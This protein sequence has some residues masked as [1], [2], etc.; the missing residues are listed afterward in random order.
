MTARHTDLGLALLD[1]EFLQDPYPLYARMQAEGAV[2]RV[3]ASDFFAVCGRAAVEEAVA[4]PDTFSSNLTGAIR[5]MPDGTVDLLPLDSLGSPTQALATADDPAHAAHRRMLIPHLAAKRIGALE[6]FVAQTMTALWQD[7]TDVGVTEWMSAVANPLPMKVICEL[8]GIPREDTDRVGQWAYASTQVL[9]GRVDDPKLA[10][11][12]TAALELAG[13]I[14]EQMEASAA[15][16]GHTLL[17][18]LARACGTGEV[19]LITAQVMLVTLFS[20]GGESTASLIGSATQII[21]SRP[22]LQRRLR[23]DPTL[24]PAFLEEVL[25]FEPPFRAHYRHVVADCDLAGHPLDA[26]SRLLLLWGAANRDPAHLEA[27]H[28]FRLDRPNSKGHI[29]FGKGAHFCVGAALARLESRVV[30]EHLITRT[31]WIEAAAPG[32]W[33]PS[34]LVRRLAELPLSFS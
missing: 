5:Y 9:D 32:R 19:E 11:A 12:G 15:E 10:A 13:Y 7:V 21:A 17:G 30:L 33:L 16:P 2:H 22:E 27:P 18:D 24:I 8:I 1:A 23:D 28:E 3:G 14:A 34:L 31:S 4:R 20:A 6:T 29:A 25:R 26:G